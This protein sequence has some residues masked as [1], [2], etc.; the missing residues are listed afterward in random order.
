[1][2]SKQVEAVLKTAKPTKKCFL[3]VFSSN[4][5]PI[6]TKHHYPHCFVANTDKSG[7]VGEHWVAF[8]VKSKEHCEY[9]DSLG[10]KPN[11]DIS[12]YLNSYSKIQINDRVLQLP[13][14]DACGHYCIYFLLSRCSGSSYCEIVDTLYKTRSMSDYLAKSFVRQIFGIG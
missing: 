8:F 1:M 6:K 10:E 7:N 13:F 9:F 5:I 3:G 14:S 2:N 11:S 12:T 4:N